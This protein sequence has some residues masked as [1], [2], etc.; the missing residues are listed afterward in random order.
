M[1][2]CKGP[3]DWNGTVTGELVTPTAAAL[4]RVL[5]GVADFEN[6][7]KQN[8]HLDEKAAYAQVRIGRPP[9]FTPRVV[10]VGGGTKDF[11]KHPNILRLVL[12][13]DPIFDDGRRKSPG[14][15]VPLN[16]DHESAEKFDVSKSKHI[17]QTE[18]I[19]EE[20]SREQT[21]THEVGVEIKGTDQHNEESLPWQVDKLTLLQTNIDDITSEVLSHV[22]DLL[23]ENGAIDAWVQPIVMKKG[24]SA[25][26]LNCIFHSSSSSSSNGSNEEGKSSTMTKL[27]GIIFRHTTTLG[28]RIQ[29][30]IE[31]AAL[32][33]KF[34]KV[35]TV[36]GA[37]NEIA[38]NGIVDVKLGFLGEEVVSMKAEFDHCKLIAS[39]TGIPL[40]EI[41]DNA[42]KLAREQLS[43]YQ[44]F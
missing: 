35:Q 12:G 14:K 8:G 7:K 28:V 10:G 24:R 11:V 27:M 9:A 25:H 41:A 1:K 2:T 44:M 30:D 42:I 26:Q 15:A 6:A 23:L 38:R 21:F 40:K 13:E 22:V 20:Q 36:Y 37:A 32:K 34:I 17:S 5:T 18:V 16:I 33:R 3:G 29:R 31:R 39:E 19:V 43:T 4:L